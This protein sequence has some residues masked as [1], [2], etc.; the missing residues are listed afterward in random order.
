LAVKLKLKARKADQEG[1]ID[2][3]RGKL[4]FIPLCFEALGALSRNSVNLV[5]HIAKEWSLNS[6]ISHSIALQAVIS[7]ISIGIQ[8]GNAMCLVASSR[9]SLLRDLDMG[10]VRPP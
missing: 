6:G 4:K 9:A 5:D 3:A 10:L 7:K 2:T 8:R 1:M